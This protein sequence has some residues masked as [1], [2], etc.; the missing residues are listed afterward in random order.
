[1]AKVRSKMADVRSG[2]HPKP[3]TTAGTTDVKSEEFERRQKLK[4]PASPAKTQSPNDAV[5]SIKGRRTPGVIVL[6]SDPTESLAP[7]LSGTVDIK[8]DESERRHLDKVASTATTQSTN[9]A[10]QSGTTLPIPAV[11]VLS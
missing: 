2:N 10:V 11:I 3:D 6:C 1:M 7:A 8:S 4:L 9:A 5:Q